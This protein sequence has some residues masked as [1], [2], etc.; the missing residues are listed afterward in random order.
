[1]SGID[2]SEIDA[3]FANDRRTVRPE[4]T[5]PIGA[6]GQFD[7]DGDQHR[8]TTDHDPGLL[9]RHEAGERREQ[10]V[11]LAETHDV[12]LDRRRRGTLLD[13]FE[14][15]REDVVDLRSRPQRRDR[16]MVRR[17]GRESNRYPSLVGTR[18]GVPGDHHGA[19]DRATGRG[20]VPGMN[21]DRLC[22]EEVR[23]QSGGILR[24]DVEGLD[25]F[26]RDFDVGEHRGRD[27]RGEAFDDFVR[28]IREEHVVGR[29]TTFA[30]QLVE[31]VSIDAVADAEGEDPGGAG[32][33]P[34]RLNDATVVP[35]VSVGQERHDP[36][37]RGEGPFRESGLR[38]LEAS[39]AVDGQPATEKFDVGI[40]VLHGRKGDRHREREAKTVSNHEPGPAAVHHDR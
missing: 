7:G 15:R 25:A 28:A 4:E 37:R 18:A 39:L 40:L 13:R 5:L 8:T 36:H 3:A 2:E 33:V 20:G 14:V 31:Q 23:K 9:H 24:Q 19:F 1:M 38:D 29:A 35:D 11:V 17:R 10:R 26:D 32:V 22:I 6:F 30:R 16:A 21:E 12:G 27:P 34:N